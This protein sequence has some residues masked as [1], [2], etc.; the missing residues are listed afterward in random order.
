MVKFSIVLS[1]ATE[2]CII[3]CVR[4]ASLHRQNNVKA[5]LQLAECLPPSL[6]VG[7]SHRSLSM[8]EKNGRT[9]F[10][11]REA[12]HQIHNVNALLKLWYFFAAAAAV[13]ASY[14]ENILCRFSMSV[15]ERTRVFH[16][17]LY[18]LLRLLNSVNECYT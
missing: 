17:R 12:T 10:L 9:R 16:V 13:A 15:R 8:C 5:F 2:T 3:E 18:V 1:H 11:C 6:Y 14:T 7:L 4:V